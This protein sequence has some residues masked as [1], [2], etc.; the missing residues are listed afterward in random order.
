MAFIY[1]VY[2]TG[3]EPANL[4]APDVAL[5][6]IELHIVEVWQRIELWFPDY[7][8]GVFAIIRS[9]LLQII[10]FFNNLWSVWQDSNLWPDPSKGPTL[11]KLRYI[12]WRYDRG[13]NSNF[14]I[15][16]QEYLPL[17]DH[18]LL[19]Y[20]IFSIIYGQGGKI[21]THDLIFPKYAL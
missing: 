10:C 18:T 16:K 5:Y 3:F 19:K 2:M 8:T 21:W 20:L 13:S 14:L 12:Q 1:L 15:T 6:Q 4:N 9:Y 7:K 11:T 17:Y